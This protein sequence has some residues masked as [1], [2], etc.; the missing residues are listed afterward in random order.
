MVYGLERQAGRTEQLRREGYHGLDLEKSALARTTPIVG[1]RT[2][3]FRK[4]DRSRKG[5]CEH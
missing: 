2:I 3:G 4:S 1:L 5:F